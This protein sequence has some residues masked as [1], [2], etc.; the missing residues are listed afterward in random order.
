[1]KAVPDDAR[2]SEFGGSGYIWAMRDVDRWNDVSKQ[3]TCGIAGY[4]S[5]VTWIAAS[6]CESPDHP[7]RRD[8]T[9]CAL[10]ASGTA[11]PARP[12]RRV[13]PGVHPRDESARMAARASVTATEHELGRVQGEIAK[14]I[15]ALKDGVPASVVKDEL[16]RLEA[17]RSAFRPHLFCKSSASTHFPL[18]PL[19]CC[20]SASA[21]P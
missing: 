10:R 13:L 12:V 19:G 20:S 7:T 4:A 1:V 18:D 15:Q 21:S 2:V 3:A 5:V 17:R 9:A 11:P 14:L 6:A 16:I 8:R